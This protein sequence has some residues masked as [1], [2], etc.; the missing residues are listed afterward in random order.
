MPKFHFNVHDGHDYPDLEGMELPTMEAARKHAA[1]Y[2]G[3]LLQ[4]SPETFWQGGE[5]RM[6][7]TDAAGLVLFSLM[8]VGCDAP[9]IQK[10]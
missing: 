7:A 3:E 4:S 8:F 6:D 5:W 2:A 1:R 10:G 9:S